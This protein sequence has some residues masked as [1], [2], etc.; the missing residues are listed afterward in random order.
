MVASTTFSRLSLATAAALAMLPTFAQGQAGAIPVLPNRAVQVLIP[1]AAGGPAD[2]LARVVGPK[3][4]E[5][6]GRSIIPDNRPSNNG[7]VAGELVAH[8]PADGTMLL[9]GNTGTQAIN[10][11]LYKNLQYSPVNDFAP[12]TNAITSGLYAVANPKLPAESIK[13]LIAYAKTV[14]GKINLAIAGA[15]GQIAG[16]ALKLQAGIDLNDV[17]YKG[18]TPAVIAVISGESMMTLTNLSNVEPHV[19]AGKLKLIGLTSAKRDP[20]MPNVPTF[21]ENGLAGYDVSMWY[22]FFAPVKTPAPVIQA[23]YREFSKILNM[24]DIKSHLVGAGYDMIINTP[25]QFAEQVK[26]DYERYR[27]I[28]L[29]S[30]MPLQ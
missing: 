13:D 25:E 9:V 29:D 3:L 10:A 17:W 21:A 1:N 24:P 7:I 12:I 18:G 2:L 4:G 27:K 16:N 11:T 6:I 14:P 22:G 20:A 19:K 23:Y 26:R 8:G 5:A 28:I 30:N 15:T